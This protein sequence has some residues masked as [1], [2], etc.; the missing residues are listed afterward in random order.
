MSGAFDAGGA[1]AAWS[2]LRALLRQYD[3]RPADAADG[4]RDGGAAGGPRG[5]G[6]LRVAVVDAVL[7]A[8]RRLRLPRWLV[9]PFGPAAAAAGGGP[10]CGLAG[11]GA[12]DGAAL[13][14]V[15]L[16]HGRLQDGAE[17]LARHLDHWSRAAPAIERVRS[18]SGWAPYGVAEQLLQSLAAEARAAGAARDDALQASLQ[19]AQSSLEGALQEHLTL[20]ATDA[21]MAAGKGGAAR[22]AAAAAGGW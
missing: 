8:E 13:L 9:E 16:R 6:P 7:S 4:G 11:A 5:G 17:L 22:M 18:A 3:E 12:P 2:K 20:V 10:H 1:R 15:Y 14:R 19:R 21:Q